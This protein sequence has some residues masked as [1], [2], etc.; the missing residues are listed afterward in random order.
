MDSKYLQDQ[1]QPVPQVAEARQA[2]GVDHTASPRYRELNLATLQAQGMVTHDGGRTTVAEDFRIIKRPLLRKA[3]ASGAEAIRHGNLIVVTSAM[4]GEGK[5][6]C[7][8][9][10]RKS[11]V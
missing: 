2:Y 4:P 7:A 5:T 10:D 11:V 6:Y 1:P 9:K 8:V 3:R